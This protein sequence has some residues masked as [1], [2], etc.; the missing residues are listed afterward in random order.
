M[1]IESNNLG[2]KILIVSLIVFFIGANILGYYLYKKGYFGLR[3][4]INP[5]N[6]PTN[7]TQAVEKPDAV[8]MIPGM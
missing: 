1:A 7:T 5:K 2:A 4:D 3:A 6:S 8:Y